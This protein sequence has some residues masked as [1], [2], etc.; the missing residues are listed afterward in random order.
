MLHRAGCRLVHHGL[1][2]RC[3]NRRRLYV[4]AVLCAD[5]LSH[6]CDARNQVL[7]VAFV[8]LERRDEGVDHRGLRQRIGCCG[9]YR[10]MYRAAR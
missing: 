2:S 10:H 8:V 6:R 7:L 1:I 9:S 4:R 5:A 3:A